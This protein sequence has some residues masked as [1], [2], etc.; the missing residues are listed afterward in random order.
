MKT[1]IKKEKEIWAVY[2]NTDLTEGKGGQYVK[3]YCKKET[4]AYRLGK[5][6]HPDF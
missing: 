1:K 4:T 5:G 3:H 2:S 6:Q